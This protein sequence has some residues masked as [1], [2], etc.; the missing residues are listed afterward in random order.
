[1]FYL[2]LPISG[3]GMVASYFFM[4]LQYNRDE[5]IMK[6]LA[7]IDS[8][9]NAI[10]IASTISILIALTWAG[11]S[12][13]WSDAHILV[14]LLVGL[15][16][17]VAFMVYEASGLAAEAVVPVR[18]FPNWTSRIIYVNT[19]MN[20]V[21]IFWCFFYFPLYFQGVRLSMPARSACSSCPSL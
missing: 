21:L 20:S 1:M 13:P 15:A 7:R 3:L 11:P 19:F 6:K 8:V 10:M 18:L 2:N 4:N 12:Y 17:L 14:P 16:G 9:G 5:P